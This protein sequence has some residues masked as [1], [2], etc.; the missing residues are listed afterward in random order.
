MDASCLVKLVVHEDA[1]DRVRSFVNV[2]SSFYTTPICFSEALTVLKRKWTRN[3]IDTETY[4]SATGELV[5]GK[6]EIEDIG[7]ANPLIHNEVEALAR[8]HQLDLSDAL[9][10]V[11]I[12][13]GRYR[14]L[15]PDSASVLI[16]ADSGLAAAATSEGIR[17]WNCLTSPVPP[18]PSKVSVK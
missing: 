11:T 5:F 14:V 17:T 8:K 6:V 18:W 3:E 2:H 7:L 4:F 15:G 10:L 9:Q 16:T 13:R 1:S 12:L